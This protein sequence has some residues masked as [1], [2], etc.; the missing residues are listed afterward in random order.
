MSIKIEYRTFSVD[1]IELSHIEYVSLK[2]K[3]RNGYL[4]LNNHLPNISFYSAEK[5][6]F[7]ELG[8]SIG[9]VL[10]G[11]I[12]LGVFEEQIE[13]KALLTILLGAPAY[14]GF[15]GVV[16]YGFGLIFSLISFLSYSAKRKVLVSKM[17]K[18]FK[19]SADYED[20]CRIRKIAYRP[21]EGGDALNEILKS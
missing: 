3:S 5:E 6:R 13:D 9:M 12:L 21:T 11:A 15:F 1:S 2:L 10:V 14:L 18:A 20:Y 7:K 8:I 17:K 16:I 19:E 4:D